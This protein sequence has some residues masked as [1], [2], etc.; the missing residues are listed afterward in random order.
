[1]VNYLVFP[2]TSGAPYMDYIIAD[3]H[4]TP[5]EHASQYTERLVLLPQTYQVNFYEPYLGISEEEPWEGDMVALRLVSGVLRYHLPPDPKTV[6][7]VNFNK[8]DKLEP[9]TF[10][11]WMAIL[12]RVP[13]GVL[14][15]LDPSP[16]K[17]SDRGEQIKHRLCEAAH[18]HGVQA[19]R[20][21]WAPRVPKADHL[22]RHI[23]ADVFLDTF[24]YGAHST[25]TDALRG[26]VPLLT[27]AGET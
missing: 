15:L 8:I 18:A 9:E 12:R 21:I 7:F 24:T 25:A 14:W 11:V 26:G 5:P 16:P 6:V 4:V 13:N 23:A 27:V 10:R 17:T 2:G 3:R 1:K 22:R 19:E 20:L